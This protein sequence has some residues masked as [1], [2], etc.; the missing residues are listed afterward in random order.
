MDCGLGK[1]MWATLLGAVMLAAG[2]CTP[3]RADPSLPE[4][5]LDSGFRL[6]YDLDFARAHQI[7]SSWQEQHPDDPLGPACEAAG[8][9]FSEFDRLGVL[10]SQFYENNDAFAARKKLS[11][12]P[13]VRDRFNA[14]LARAESRAKTHLAVNPKD[15]DA[16]FAMTLASGLKADYAALIE[17]RNLSSLHYTREASAWARRLLAVDPHCY[18]AHIATGFS[19]YIVGSMAAPLRW[20]LRLGGVSGDKSGGIA[21]L[22]LTAQHGRYLAPFARILLAIAYVR[23]KDRAQARQILAS[24]RDEFPGNPLFAREIAHL[25]SSH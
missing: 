15:H 7:F 25:D 9:L 12:D 23:D 21:E 6:L 3:A 16:L 14:A 19:K 2:V 20:F 22:Q 8:L 5:S 17:K 13:A 18:D 4:V 1:R 24:L 10:E 11:P